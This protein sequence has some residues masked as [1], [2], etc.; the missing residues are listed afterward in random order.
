[1]NKENERVVNCDRFDPLR[2]LGAG[3]GS[4]EMMVQW[5]EQSD[6][7]ARPGGKLRKSL[8]GVGL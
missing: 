2:N 5:V 8:S 4:V 1:M 6:E 3:A 7:I